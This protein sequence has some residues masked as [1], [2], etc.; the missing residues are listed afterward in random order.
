MMNATNDAL[1]KNDNECSIHFMEEPSTPTMTEE[2]CDV[3][4]MM[5]G[6]QDMNV[7]QYEANR[8]KRIIEDLKI[9]SK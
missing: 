8:F 9:E 3:N 2:S 6:F 7:S 5:H 1:K 4:P